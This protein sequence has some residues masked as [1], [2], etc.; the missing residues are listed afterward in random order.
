MFTV[1]IDLGTTSSVVSYVKDGIPVVCRING[2]V[3]TPSVVNYSGNQ[4]IVG[5]EAVCKADFDATVFSAKRFMGTENMFCG[6]NAIEV[7]ADILSHLKRNVE[8][9][10]ERKI[11]A[12]VI[13]VPAHFS[14]AQRTSTKHAASIAGIRVLRLIN[15]PTSAALAF[16]LNERKDG[17]FA[18]YDFGGG[19]FDFSILRLT[20][21]IFQVLAT[22]GDNYLGGD[23]IDNAILRHNSQ[24]CGLEIEEKEKISGKQVAKFLKEHLGNADDIRKEFIHR[25]KSY[26]FQ[27]TPD[28]LQKVS[29]NFLQKTLEISDQVL[30]DANITSSALDG[31]V[32][33]GGMTKLKLIKEK[34]QKY[35]PTKIFDNINPE[36]AVAL[37]A[38]NYADSITHKNHYLL[39]IDVVPLTLGIETLGGGVDKIIYRNTPIPVIEKREYTTYQDNQAGI[40]FHVVQGERP[41]ASECRSIANFELSGIPPMPAGIPRIEVEFSVDVNGLLKIEAR[42]KKTSAQQT[43]TVD[44]SSGLS[45]DKI[46]SI[47]EKAAK[48]QNEDSILA[49]NIFLKIES[50]R[51][52]KFWESVIDEIPSPFQ[53]EAKSLLINLKT[54]LDADQCE[55]ALP[56]RRK[57]EELFGQFLDDIIN[58]HLSGI[59]VADLTGEQQ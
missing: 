1:G 16:G 48:N 42:D 47:L 18:V 46:T 38:A 55:D 54:A 29:Q 21:G 28:V 57:L 58:A 36:E 24:L 12:A 32:M 7:S 56:L 52:I 6:K 37:G 40:K 51:M 50:E 3:A 49:R 43:I 26:L 20:N 19:T 15:E 9:D 22:G 2:S 5:R 4:V 59:A 10:L 23:D 14:D 35:F 8:R 13:A 39:L 27:L 44:P 34:I 17:V 41:L 33:I 25:N 45:I 11:D 31:I 30:S 53:K